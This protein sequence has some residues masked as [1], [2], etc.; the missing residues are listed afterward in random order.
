MAF[1][2]PGLGLPGAATSSFQQSST[3][4]PQSTVARTETLQPRTEWRFEVAFGR[5]YTIKLTSGTAEHWGTELA[6]DITYTFTGYKGA[7]FSW[8]GCTLEVAGTAEAEYVGEDTTYAVEW[9]NVHGALSDLRTASASG[10]EAPRV[11]VVGPDHTGK[12][13]L[14]RTLAAWAVRLGKAPLVVNLDSRQGMLAPPGSFTAAVVRDSM[15]VELGFGISPITGPTSLPVKTPLVHSWPFVS[16]A[17]DQ[18]SFKQV[19]TRMALH[20]SGRL[21]ADADTKVSGMIVDTPGSLNDPRTSY[22]QLHHVISELS[23]THILVVESERLNADLQRRYTSTIP[24]IK[25][26]KPAGAV[27]RD[28]AFLRMNR[29]RQIRSYFFGPS[30]VTLNP[31][32]HSVAFN[33]LHIYRFNTASS[34]TEPSFA[35]GADDDYEPD[36][37]G[38]LLEKVVPTAALTASLVAIKFCSGSKSDDNEIRDSTVM[39]YAYVAE[40]DDTRKRVRFLAPHPQKWG[41]RALLLGS[42][43]EAVPDLIV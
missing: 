18:A 5:S 15:D 26:R 8:Q 12:T 30:N 32:S 19:T 39:G 34:A 22:D 24:V 36:P 13:S 7:I 23:I 4:D 20:V 29:A 3:A 2:I 38:G 21:E 27:E 10:S 1:S 43:P 33:E 31:H 9:L 41:D 11:L 17:D 6:T 42:F 16:T 14:V 25:L 40:V 37:A 35:P 28:K